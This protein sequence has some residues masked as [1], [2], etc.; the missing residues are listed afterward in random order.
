MTA[1][2]TR[3]EVLGDEAVG[4]DMEGIPSP[5]EERPTTGDEKD[6]SKGSGKTFSEQLSELKSRSENTLK[7]EREK[8]ESK[9]KEA[10]AELKKGTSREAMSKFKGTQEEWNERKRKL[11]KARDEAQEALDKIG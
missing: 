1:D 8:A 4:I 9:L 10:K 5:F 2:E 7:A 3:E 6:E 11:E